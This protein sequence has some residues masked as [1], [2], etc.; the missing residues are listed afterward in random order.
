MSE[1]ASRQ[2]TDRAYFAL[3]KLFAYS[4]SDAYI[5]HRWREVT[6]EQ[7]PFEKLKQLAADGNHQANRLPYTWNQAYTIGVSAVLLE[8]MKDGNPDA[9]EAV[10]TGSAARGNRMDIAVL[11]DGAS[12][13]PI[14]SHIGLV[15]VGLRHGPG[16]LYALPV[17]FE[18]ESNSIIAPPEVGVV[19]VGK[20][21]E[22]A[23]FSN[24]FPGV[25]LI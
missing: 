8:R 22:T 19:A 7:R 20:A 24:R 1:K 9:S 25:D 2:F 15:G 13:K 16:P 3:A 18:H 5:Q 12:L 6:P 23:K 11:S 21:V 10:I 4:D 14:E 17:L